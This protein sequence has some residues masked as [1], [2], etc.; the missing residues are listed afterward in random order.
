VAVVSD[1]YDIYRAISEHWGTTLRDEVIASGATLV[2]RPDS[3]DPVE[4]V[5]ES[6][7]RL[8]EAFGHSLN[9]KGY[10]VLNHVRV[11]QGDGINPDTIRAILQRITDDGYAADNVAFGMGGA[12]LQRLDRDTQ[13][14]ALKCSA[15]RVEGEWIDVYKDPV[16]DA[17]KASKRGRMRLLR[18]LDDGSLHTVPLPA[19]GDDTLPDGFED[20]MVTVWENGRLLHDQRLDDIRT[21]AAAGH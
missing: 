8:D 11:I 17:G 21:R 20:A 1:S 2:I 7:H 12:L 18:R 10:R 15:A 9:S 16:T 19:N 14:F 5:A 4:V 3:G 6:L 13:K